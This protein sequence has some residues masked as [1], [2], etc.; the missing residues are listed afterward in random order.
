MINLHTMKVGYGR[1]IM[2]E[3]NNAIWLFVQTR[4]I[5]LIKMVASQI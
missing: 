5:S 4:P 2:G 1:V 3:A